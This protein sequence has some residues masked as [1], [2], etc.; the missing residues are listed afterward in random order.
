[1]FSTPLISCSIGVATVSAATW[2]LAPG[3]RAD[4]WIVGGATSGYWAMGSFLRATAPTIRM[5]IERTV[6][7]IGRLIKKCE[8]I[9][10]PCRGVV[11]GLTGDERP[12]PRRSLGGRA[13]GGQGLLGT[14]C[15]GGARAG[16]ARTGAG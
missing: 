7:K 12:A 14:A 8:I 15:A 13:G 9:G 4:T 6:A 10:S 11:S 2:A 5:T 1:M 16:R 3:Y